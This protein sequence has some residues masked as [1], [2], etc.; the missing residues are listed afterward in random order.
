[1]RPDNDIDLLVEFIPE[2]MV[3]LFKYSDLMLD[4]S[5]FIG[6]KADLVSKKRL[7][8]LIR[9]SVLNEGRLLYAA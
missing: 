6:R 2:A 3:D 1:M 5:E 9:A 7:K 8:P 4:L